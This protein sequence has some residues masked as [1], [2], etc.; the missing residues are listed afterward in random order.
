VVEA[1]SDF[2]ALVKR[3]YDF[4]VSAGLMAPAGVKDRLRT[5]AE[6]AGSRIASKK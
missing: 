2:H 6:R 1:Y 4:E 5:L 3:E